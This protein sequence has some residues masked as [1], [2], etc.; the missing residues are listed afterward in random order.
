[1]RRI[2]LTILAVLMV[3]CGGSDQISNLTISSPDGSLGVKIEVNK[4]GVLVYSVI[5]GGVSIV[6]ESVLGVVLDGESLSS[7]FEIVDHKK[8]SFDQ[9]FDMPWGQ[10]KRVE[11]RY[12][13]VVVNL[14]QKDSD[15]NLE[16]DFRVFDDAVAYRYGFKGDGKMLLGDELSE[17]V[18]LGNPKTWYSVA[19]FDSYES[20]YY[21][22]VLDSVGWV[23]TPVIMRREDGKHVAINEASILN[24][25]DATLNHVGGGKFKVEL[26]PW[27]SGEKARVDGGSYSPWRVIQIADD[28]VG[29]LSSEALL[30]LSPGNALG[31]VGYCKPM[32]YVGIWW[33]FHLGTREW[34]EG[35]RQGARTYE[36]MRMIDFAYRHNIGGVVVEGWNKGWSNWGQV[37]A[38]DYVTP[39]N[40]YDLKRVADYAKTCGVRLIMHH[41]T[42]GDIEGYENVMDSA[43]ALCKSLG[44]SDLKTG[45]AGKVS[46]GEHHHGQQ[47]VAHF[48]K[49][50][51]TAA[52]YGIA[53]DLHEPI[54]GSGLERTYPNM[55]TRE[56]VRGLEW[57]AWSEGN[58]SGHTAL[59]P[60]LRGLNAPTDY[61]PG[62]FD[63]LYKR[64]YGRKAWNVSD[65]VMKTTRVHSTLAHQLSLM[66]TIY[67]PWVMAADKIDNYE[68][69]PA[70][71]FV[72]SLNPDYDESRYL[73][74]QVGEYLVV[75]RR[76]GDVWY[77]GATNNEVARELTTK[78]DFLGDGTWEAT[79]YR[80]A[81]DANWKTNPTSYKIETKQVTPSDELMLQLASGG[82][83]AIV[84]KKIDK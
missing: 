51:K 75:A 57:E 72:S 74:A 36:A 31:D 10:N 3:G 40:G 11:N 82:G 41:E 83:C 47:M 2:L 19:N 44:I 60:F 62:I 43:F 23:A 4:E 33:D 48:E 64:A 63:I 70:F 35:A 14:R 65:S 78:L 27:Q 17:I 34:A 66:L 49:I 76:S 8:S 24:Y 18:I 26:T 53:L 7:N 16:I 42:G 6:G 39:A 38:F 67:S 21:M 22:D 32:T 77:V 37:G 13:E 58:V 45:H 28:A 5:D 61:T 9:A 20:E 81:D 80:D 73:D 30:K 69:H 12:N 68:N 59:I 55:M 1:M 79:I 29:I 84:F 25:P 15:K 56:G 46:T 71:K 54:K 52:K 50:A